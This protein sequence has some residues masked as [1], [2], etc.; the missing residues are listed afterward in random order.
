MFDV[1]YLCRFTLYLGFGVQKSLHLKRIGV[2][3]TD[4]TQVMEDRTGA[5]VAA[6][7]PKQSPN[8][9]LRQ[10]SP[11]LARIGQQFAGGIMEQKA[12]YVGMD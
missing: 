4:F 1:N 7:L 12:I 8:G 10:Q 3:Q 5:G 11:H 6:S 2:R 9:C